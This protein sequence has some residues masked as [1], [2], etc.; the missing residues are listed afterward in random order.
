MS[1]LNRNLISCYSHCWYYKCYQLGSLPHH[2]HRDH[3]SIQT[4]CSVECI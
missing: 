4:T 3:Y 2:V 1:E